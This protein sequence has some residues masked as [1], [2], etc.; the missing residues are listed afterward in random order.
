[1]E[2]IGSVVALK[3]VPATVEW[4]LLTD[5]EFGWY[6]ISCIEDEEEI[7]SLPLPPPLLAVFAPAP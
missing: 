3:G 7:E 2:L 1:M 6:F 5:E 4:G